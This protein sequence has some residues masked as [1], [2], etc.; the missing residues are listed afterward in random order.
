M[1]GAGRLLVGA[2]AVL[3]LL[4]LAVLALEHLGLPLGRLPGDLGFRGR[5]VQIF[6]PLGTSLLL[7]LLASL[8]L[9]G[10]SRWRH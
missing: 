6:V 8:L 9:D 2:G 10:L 5:Y 4:G 7:S 3:I 1:S